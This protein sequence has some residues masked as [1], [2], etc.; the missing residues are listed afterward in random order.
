MRNLAFFAAA[1]LAGFVGCAG[2]PPT[3]E[4]TLGKGTSEMKSAIQRAVAD[5]GRRDKL[6][7]TADGIEAALRGHA[8]DYGRFLGEYRRLN[9]A[10]DT[11]QVQVETLFAQ[12]DQ[13]R[14]DTRARLLELH[15]QMIRLTSAQEWLPIAKVEAD[16]L[17]ATIAVPR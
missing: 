11:T 4:A 5:P 15:F 12:F 8:A 14:R 2:T 17:Q 6:L 7:A 9:D 10:F 16:M 3:P 1:L 13:R